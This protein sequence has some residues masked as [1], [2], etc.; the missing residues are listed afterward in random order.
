MTTSET[1]FDQETA[2]VNDPQ[3][4]PI[5]G[6]VVPPGAEVEDESFDLEM[7]I[8]EE[9]VGAVFAMPGRIAARKTGH[10]W[11]SP[12]EDEMELLG[13][14]APAIRAMIRRWVSETPGPFALLVI[15]LLVVYLP[16]AMQE[17]AVQKA[18]KENPNTQ[19]QSPEKRPRM[20]QF[21]P[22]QQTSKPESVPSSENAGAASQQ[23]SSGSRPDVNDW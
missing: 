10:E 8:T 16:K 18:E 13:K 2:G 22:E 23:S 5:V 7:F 3:Q 11:W 14:A 4:Q 1:E 20:S 17:M 12:D 21:D 6:D 9:F 19:S 15:V